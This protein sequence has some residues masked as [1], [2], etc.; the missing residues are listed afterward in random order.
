MTVAAAATAATV[1]F[2]SPV[3]RAAGS[4]ARH[5]SAGCPS[6]N[7]V[8]SFRGLVNTL[9]FSGV[10]KGDEPGLGGSRTIGL[11][12]DA[13]NLQIKLDAKV[14]GS[15]PGFG[16]LTF[17]TGKT[18]VG[19]IS[20]VDTFGSTGSGMKGT[21]NAIGVP[22]FV[23]ASLVLWPK[24]CLYQL[25]VS[26]DV[27][28]SFSGDQAIR[29][30]ADIWGGAYT[31][32][33]PIP[34]SLKLGGASLIQAY[35]DGCAGARPPDVHGCFQF[36]GDWANDFDTLKR[37]HSIVAVNCTPARHTEGAAHI[38]WSLTPIFAK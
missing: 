35:H 10:A 2:A 18:K 23:T 29:P 37:C 24:G 7:R 17:F 9:S 5:A 36:G 34:A 1:L 13:T 38:S 30:G 27:K 19:S 25:Q 31:P 15:L 28:A 3:S 22:R 32:R 16:S 6:W 14:S 33:R 4:E 8:R 21:S 11:D 26:Y 20:A 12:R